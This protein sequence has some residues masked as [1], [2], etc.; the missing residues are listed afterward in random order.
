M[1]L[2]LPFAALLLLI[3]VA[4][5]ACRS[6]HQETVLVFTAASLTDVMGEVADRFTDDT[7]IGV[8]LHLGGSTA[9]AQQII[10][11][12]PG[13][14][15]I[16]AGSSPMD[17]LEASDLISPQSR[18]NILTNS[19][20]LVG[21]PSVSGSAGIGSLEDLAGSNV[22]LT[23]ADPDLAPAGRYAKEALISL[24]LW[25]QLEPNILPS[26]DVRAALSYVETKNADVGIIYKTDI[27]ANDTARILDEIPHW[28]HSPIVY[29]AAVIR[30]S[31]HNEG[32]SRFVE[33]LVSDDAK[34]IFRLHG[35]APVLGP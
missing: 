25:D 10:R 22:R 11:G 12:A 27:Q 31:E 16:S 18:R 7:G 8:D 17:L 13:D 6:G 23:I 26:S 29:P 33:Y 24:D 20:A 19:L 21:I 32:A 30:R 34:D 4:V 15:F 5:G 3:M 35:F 9:L 1:K 28:T 14:V 2:L